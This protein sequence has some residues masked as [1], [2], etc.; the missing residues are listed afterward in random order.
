MWFSQFFLVKKWL[1][2]LRRYAPTKENPV[3]EH[4][5]HG[6]CHPPQAEPSQAG[7]DKAREQDEQVVL[8]IF[9]QEGKFLRKVF[10]QASRGAVQ[11]RAAGGVDYGGAD[12]E[13]HHLPAHCQAGPLKV[14]FWRM[15]LAASHVRLRE[16]LTELEAHLHKL[17]EDHKNKQLAL[18]LDTRCSGWQWGCWKTDSE[19]YGNLKLKLKRMLSRFRNILFSENLQMHNIFHSKFINKKHLALLV[20]FRIAGFVCFLETAKAISV[21]KYQKKKGRRASWMGG[22]STHLRH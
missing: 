10:I 21:V 8:K 19:W 6:E 22:M 14:R 4:P 20:F 16:T 7:W 11:G 15:P 9:T 13:G 18:S 1:E 2:K 12:A 3:G 5:S 17:E